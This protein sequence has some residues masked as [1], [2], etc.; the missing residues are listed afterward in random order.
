MMIYIVTVLMMKTIMMLTM[1]INDDDVTD[2]CHP[3][4]TSS[5]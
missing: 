3:V 5:T 2:A 4:P 1:T